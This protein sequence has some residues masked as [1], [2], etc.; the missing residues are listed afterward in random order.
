MYRFNEE[1]LGTSSDQE[2][3]S[4]VIDINSRRRI[5]PTKRGGPMVS[6]WPAN[7]QVAWELAH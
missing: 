5:R 3:R 4:N 6:D 1:R 2:D 7:V